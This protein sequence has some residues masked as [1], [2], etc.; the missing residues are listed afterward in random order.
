MTP[1]FHAIAPHV[2]IAESQVSQAGMQLRANWQRAYAYG[3]AVGVHVDVQGWRQ[4]DGSLWTLNQLVPLTSDYLGIDMDLLVAQ[5]EYILDERGGRVTRLLLGPIEGYT[6]D[7][8]Q[9][10]V[11]K[12]AGH[13]GGH[14]L[15]LSGLAPG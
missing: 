11:H 8:G 12:H 1:G 10:K 3:R 2:T 4:P 6:P 14:I 15:D 9:V 5:V 13:K 7:P